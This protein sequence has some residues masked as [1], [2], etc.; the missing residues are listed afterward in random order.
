MVALTLDQMLKMA[1]SSS[2][3]VYYRRYSMVCFGKVHRLMGCYQTDLAY[4]LMVFARKDFV[5]SSTRVSRATL[6]VQF[7]PL[8]CLGSL[9]VRRALGQAFESQ[10]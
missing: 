9:A 2:L 5:F 7:P 8:T 3:L 4:Y 10:L 1:H 6:L